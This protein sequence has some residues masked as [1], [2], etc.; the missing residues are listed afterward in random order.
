[1]ATTSEINNDLSFSVV[2]IVEDVLQQHSSRSSDVGLVSRKVEES[3]ESLVAF[4][5][6]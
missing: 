6:S 3:C 4:V 2:S 1:M 5:F